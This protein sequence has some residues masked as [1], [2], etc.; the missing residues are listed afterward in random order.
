M[1]RVLQR[2]LAPRLAYSDQVEDDPVYGYKDVPLDRCRHPVTVASVFG[3]N[4]VTPCPQLVVPGQSFC[5]S[6]LGQPSA[7][8][9]NDLRAALV[10]IRRAGTLE[11][12]P[13]YL[14]ALEEVAAELRDSQ[15]HVTPQRAR[16]SS[17]SSAAASA[18]LGVPVVPRLNASGAS[19]APD[20]GAAAVAG[21]AGAPRHTRLEHL[22]RLRVGQG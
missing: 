21:H 17:V 14:E 18:A 22:V 20:A 13:E 9:Y 7:R 2:T 8:E 12:E 3:G 16:T 4:E 15:A 6:H 10:Q 5:V 1:N 19:H 11:V